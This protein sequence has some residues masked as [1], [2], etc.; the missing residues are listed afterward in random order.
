MKQQNQGQ[1]P[2]RGNQGNRQ[3]G[4]GDRP[5]RQQDQRGGAPQQPGGGDAG[6]QR[7]PREDEER[8]G[9]DDL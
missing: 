2:N 6:S 3:P 4:A 1:Q 8:A 9:R 5:S 7:S